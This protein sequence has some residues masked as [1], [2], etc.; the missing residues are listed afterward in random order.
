MLAYQKISRG[1]KEPLNSSVLVIMITAKGDADL[2]WLSGADG[3]LSK[4]FKGRELR[5]K[6]ED[7][8]S[9]RADEAPLVG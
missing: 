6:I 1:R 9:Q 8:I 4:P 5:R 7:G 2:S 3:Y